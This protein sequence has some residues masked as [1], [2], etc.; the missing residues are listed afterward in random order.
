MCEAI[1][2]E[3][4]RFRRIP[5][6]LRRIRTVA[7]SSLA[8][9]GERPTYLEHK[10]SIEYVGKIRDEHSSV[11][12]LDDVITQGNV[13]SA[14]RDILKSQMRCKRVIGLFLGRTE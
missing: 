13:S 11:I 1:E 14:C 3:S 7:K 6:A 10:E 5:F 9:P 8:R 12:M 2:L 4:K